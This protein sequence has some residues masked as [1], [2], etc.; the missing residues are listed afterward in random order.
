MHKNGFL[1]K[2]KCT[3]RVKQAKKKT[4]KRKI[5]RLRLKLFTPV[6]SQ[7]KFYNQ[8]ISKFSASYL[9]RISDGY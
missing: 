5:K 2:Q 1:V 8:K 7:V 9:Q 3:R 4:I 6:K